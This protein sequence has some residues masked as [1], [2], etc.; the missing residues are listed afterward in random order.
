[1]LTLKFFKSISRKITFNIY[2]RNT[3]N[4]LLIGFFVFGLGLSLAYSFF[5]LPVEVTNVV[6]EWNLFGNFF[7]TCKKLLN[8]A[9]GLFN[10][11]VTIITFLGF[12]ALI[13]IKRPLILRK[14]LYLNSTFF[15]YFL[16]ELVILRNDY[17]FKYF[18]EILNSQFWVH[19]SS[20]GELLSIPLF[21]T[22]VF[23]IL[24]VNVIIALT[25]TILAR[26][27]L[28]ALNWINREKLDL[29]YSK[30]NVAKD[31]FF[32]K[33]FLPEHKF[34]GVSDDPLKSID[35]LRDIRARMSDHNLF[36]NFEKTVDLVTKHIQ[37]LDPYTKGESA[38]TLC[39]DASWGSGKTS[40][41][42]VVHRQLFPDSSN[43][44]IDNGGLSW[45][46]FKPWS[47]G[48]Q[49][50]L[51]QGYFR[52]LAK[53]LVDNYGESVGR[54]WEE[55]VSMLTPYIEEHKL[56]SGIKSFIQEFDGFRDP[57]LEELKSRVREKVCAVPGKIVIFIDDIDRLEYEYIMIILKLVKES[58]SFPGVIF[59]LPF[60]YS[61][62]A[63]VISEK[64]GGL[65]Y[66]GTYLEKVI[67]ER[68]HISPYKYREL[69]G[70]FMVNLDKTR[71]INKLGANIDDAKLKVVF[72][73][74]VVEKSRTKF[75]EIT[76]ED[77][78]FQGNSLE[79]KPT[80]DFYVPLFDHFAKGKGGVGSYIQEYPDVL[81]DPGEGLSLVIKRH[82]THE[83]P[84]L[85]TLVDYL[86]RPVRRIMRSIASRNITND[87]NAVLNKHGI[88]G[89]EDFSKRIQDLSSST[90]LIGSPRVQDIEKAYSE[91]W[92]RHSDLEASN[93][94]AYN[95]IT[96]VMLEI[97]NR[98]KNFVD[99]FEPEI[100]RMSDDDRSFIQDWLV[101][102][103]SPREVKSLVKAMSRE[104]IS[105]WN[106]ID[107]DN[108]I[109]DYV[110][111]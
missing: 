83:I 81:G 5:S 20:L 59:V 60:D 24:S 1:M 32:V 6:G 93:N 23:L 84:N 85:D 8:S 54:S 107:I 40:L 45:I 22:F 97:F 53:V 108:F 7:E 28:T 26:F 104:S 37:G 99:K 90:S 109:K 10:G 58:A 18:W 64:R 12:V 75:L 66:F 57:T 4:Y 88:P 46:T 30:F 11:W 102:N 80:F 25:I 61:R 33:F 21:A 87:L 73:R 41:I 13:K 55:Y 38:I 39:L 69:L 19:L 34:E 17:Y 70:I 71:K 86:Q 50:E 65:E 56:L 94:G 43:F 82:I 15:G 29:I 72:D 14:L 111:S 98:V 92:N 91:F 78:N 36:R 48:S 62:V 44:D 74:F 51:V 77:N 2:I 27:K 105:D 96:Q 103:L 42:Q 9:S 35:E 79:L 49:D 100:G 101:L 95:E 68:V 106:D 89:E 47:F 52:G 76:K 31:W 110:I 16:W 3:L 63:Q 67:N